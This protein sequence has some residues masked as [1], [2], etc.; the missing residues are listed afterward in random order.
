MSRQ[1]DEPESQMMPKRPRRD[2]QLSP[3]LQSTL[4]M[5][6]HVQ[7]IDLMPTIRGVHEHMSTWMSSLINAQ[8][9]CLQAVAHRASMGRSRQEQLAQQVALRSTLPSTQNQVAYLRAQLSLRDA[10]LEHVKAERD[11][12]FVQE[13]E[14][15]AHMRLLSSEAKDWKSRV[16]T[17][18]EQVLCQESAQMAQQAHEAQAAV[19]QHYKAKW[20]QAEADLTALCQSNSAQVQSFASKMHETNEEHQQLHDAQERRIQL[21]A[22]ALRAAHQQEHQAAQVAQ[23]YQDMVHELR[24]QADE[25]PD[26]EKVLWKKALSQQADFRAEIHELHTELINMKEKSEM[27]SYLAAN[28]CKIEQS[29]PSR[30]VEAEP[31]NALN[32]LSPGRSQRWILPHEMETPNRPTSSGLQSPVGTPVQLGPS[33]LTREYSATPPGHVPPAQWGEFCGRA[34]EDGCELFGAPLDDGEPED[35]THPLQA[36]HGPDE[37]IDAHSSLVPPQADHPGAARCVNGTLLRPGNTADDTPSTACCQSEVHATGGVPLGRGAPGQQQP[38]GGF[39]GRNLSPPVPPPPPP[40]PPPVPHAS[41]APCTGPYPLQWT[42]LHT[43]PKAAGG[44]GPP[45]EPPNPGDSSS[46]QWYHQGRRPSGGG[47][48]SGG[49]NGSGGAGPPPPGGGNG[50]SSM[51]PGGTPPQQSGGAAG[52]P[53]ETPPSPPGISRPPR[54]TDPW[55]PLDRSR[56]ELPKLMLPSNYKACSILEMRQLLESWYDRCTFAIA[57]WR[58]DAQRYWL[59]EILD[60]ARARHDQWLQSTPSQRASLE[61]AYI[62]GD[63]KNIPEAQNAVESVLRTE[64]LDVIPK[65]IAESCMRH[66]YCTAELIVWH[67]MK[68]LILPHDINEVTM[69]REL[70]TPPRVTPPTLDQGR[71]WLEEMQH[72]LNLCMKTGQ[73]V[74]PRTVITFV[75]EILNGITQYY[76]TIGNVWDSLYLKHQLRDSN[77]T[78]ERVYAMLAEFLIELRLHEE[79]DKI[80]QI[81]TGSSTSVKNSMYDEYISA[82]KGKV[83]TKGKGKQREGK[84]SHPQW[85]PPCDEYWKPGGCQ[86]GHNCPKYHPRMCSMWFYETSYLTVYPPSQG[87]GQDCRIG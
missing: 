67:V 77:L 38:P 28:M 7:G 58:G 59:T 39:R 66:G 27:K 14:V 46:S 10:Q 24:R 73:Q 20:Q 31:E 13:E 35:P 26:K 57:T 43:K 36:V 50:G 1:E 49:G 40:P 17:E 16:M 22:Q 84:G 72:R 62:L 15:L 71:V 52:N 87:K 75:Q 79:Q 55:S 78:L 48:G 47:T 86:Q 30:T 42:S 5:V 37:L 56:K 3:R 65:S 33:P 12:H 63:R 41:A 82:N 45:D 18:A 4:S 9:G 85:R 83:P 53:G 80:T 29:V 2:A 70:L 6:P 25:Q 44:G 61:P 51:T 23:A 32:T 74:H 76:R 64:M 68:Q 11:N 8:D 19:D 60:R 69:Q 21:E 34:S 54:S 81:V